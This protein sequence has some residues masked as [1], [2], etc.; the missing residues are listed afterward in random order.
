M[1]DKIRSPPLLAR[2][3]LW[4]ARFLHARAEPGDRDVASRYAEQVVTVGT[5]LGMAALAERARIPLK[6]C[7]TS[8]P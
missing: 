3:R 4:Y 7:T 5:K 6:D 8:S 2:T 1:E